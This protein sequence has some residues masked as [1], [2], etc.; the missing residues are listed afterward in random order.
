MRNANKRIYSVR[1]DCDDGDD[2][3]WRECYSID[4]NCQQRAQSVGSVACII[5]I[6]ADNKL[7]KLNTRKLLEARE[8]Q[9]KMRANK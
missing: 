5:L 1:I 8:R 2:T 7:I 3:E 4:W 6:V 9:K